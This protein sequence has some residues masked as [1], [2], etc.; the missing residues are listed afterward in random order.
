MP[1]AKSPRSITELPKS[2]ATAKDS[3]ISKVVNIADAGNVEDVIR[4]RAY[5][6]FAQR[7]YADGY[8]LEDWLRAESEVRNRLTSRSA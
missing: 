1:K 5:E 6:L 3:K 2:R 8:A 7:G 4:V